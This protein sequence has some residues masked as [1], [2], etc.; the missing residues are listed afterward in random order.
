MKIYR[1][2]NLIEGYKIGDKYKGKLVV[3]IPEKK[4]IDGSVKAIFKNKTM[5]ITNFE[6][7]VENIAFPDRFGRGTYRLFYYIWSPTTQEL[8]I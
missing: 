6:T 4:F 3:A 7:P 1:P 5:I 2:K 8:L